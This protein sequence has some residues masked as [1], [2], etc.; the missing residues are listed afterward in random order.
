MIAHSRK[1]TPTPARRGFTLIELLVVVVII[2]LLAGM[3]LGALSA[4]Q[5][6]ARQQRTKA[7]IAK[8]DSVIMRKYDAYF[9]RRV[10]IST[11]G[12]TTQQAAQLRLDALRELMRMELPDREGDFLAAPVAISRP[13]LAERY[14]QR[15]NAGASAGPFRTAEMLYLIVSV[16]SADDIQLFN[17][18]EIGDVDEDGWP[19]FVDGWG[20]PIHFFRWAPGFIPQ[21]GA[22]GIQ[23]GDPVN[24][25]DAF[26]VLKLEQGAY[27]LTPLIYSFGPDR[28][29]GLDP[30]SGSGP[31][32]GTGAG[33]PDGTGDHFDNIHNHDVEAR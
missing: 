15:Y 5:E 11:L 25:H 13:A 27:Q 18:S 10:P 8:L 22:H 7:T 29:K 31:P 9:T 30:G 32:H 1:P 6:L 24:D 12:M 16:G 28:K 19:E 3:V 26:D 20:K 17:Q 23:T 33:K 14:M 21:E 4:A 2:A